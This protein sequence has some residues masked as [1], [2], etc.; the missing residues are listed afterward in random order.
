M[1]INSRLSGNPLWKNIKVFFSDANVPGEGEHKILDFIRQQRALTNYNPNTRHCL[2]GADADL[3][4]LGLATHEPHFFIFRE[5]IMTSNDKRCTLCGQ[6]G[7]FFYE[8][9]GEEK[10]KD[11]EIKKAN[12][13]EIQ[14]KFQYVRL[15]I[16]REYLDLEFKYLNLPFMYNL[17]RIIDDFVFMCFFVG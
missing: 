4:M 3:L 10:E 5:T 14:V 16:M 1:Y 13:K 7:H 2:Y 11:G 6:S 12:I 15:S 9:R 8:C 17:E